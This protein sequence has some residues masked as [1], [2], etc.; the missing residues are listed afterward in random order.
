MLPSH[1]KRLIAADGWIA[2][3]PANG[4]AKTER[5][6]PAQRVLVLSASQAAQQPASRQAAVISIRGAQD[7]EIPLSSKYRGVLRLVFED[8]SEVDD[9]HEADTISEAQAA[10]VARFVREHADARTLIV[11]CQMGIS[12]SRS[13]AAAICDVERKPYSYSAVND[14]V[15]RMVR[16]ALEREREA[17]LNQGQC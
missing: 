3:H 11:H 6:S 2:E 10:A 5:A 13:M 16:R 4:G 9:G 14:A 7:R 15:Y 12:R 8:L 1:L 17:I